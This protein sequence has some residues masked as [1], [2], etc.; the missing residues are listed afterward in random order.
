MGGSGLHAILCPFSWHP[1]TNPTYFSSYILLR[2]FGTDRAVDSCAAGVDS[3]AEGVDSRAE[4]VD[5]RAE[6]EGPPLVVRFRPGVLPT[7]SSQLMSEIDLAASSAAPSTSVRFPSEE[8]A[9][10]SPRI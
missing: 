5:S 8:Y 9:P 6:A 10:A 4:G 2:S 1:N 7:F 3:R